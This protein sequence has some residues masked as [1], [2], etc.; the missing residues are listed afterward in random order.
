MDPVKTTN[1]LLDVMGYL[2]KNGADPTV[3]SNQNKTPKHI[4]I[5]HGFKLG[6]ALLGM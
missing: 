4:A 1:E 2:F 3:K 6:I 5:E